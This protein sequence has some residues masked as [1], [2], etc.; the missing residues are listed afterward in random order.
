M[1]EV[2][3]INLGALTAIFCGFKFAI[4][5]LKKQYSGILD[6]LFRI[7]LVVGVLS[8]ALLMP[9]WLQK[10]RFPE[11]DVNLFLI[12]VYLGFLLIGFTTWL[13]RKGTLRWPGLKN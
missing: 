5:H 10:S 8:S 11:M 4:T 12:G 1:F 2:V 13:E 6:L 3:F 9:I 7:V